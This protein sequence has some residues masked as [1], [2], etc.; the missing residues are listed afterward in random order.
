[1]NAT[2]VY[3]DRSLVIEKADTSS[4]GL[5]ITFADLY[6][7]FDWTVRAEGVCKGQVCVPIPP[8]RKSEFVQNGDRFNL[9]AFCRLL[10][11]AVV[12]SDDLSAWIF[13]DA[14]SRQAGH[15]PP[16]EAPDFGLPDLDGRVHRLSDYRG[17]KVFLFSWASW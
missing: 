13:L 5:W 14:A 3:H 10:G 2:V 9:A 17:K 12:H 16:R 4:D 1:M 15:I 8:A 11:D 6:K 7:N